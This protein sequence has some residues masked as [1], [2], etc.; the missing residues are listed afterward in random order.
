MYRDRIVKVFYVCCDQNIGW[1]DLEIIHIDCDI[2]S[3]A[4]IVTMT[5]I[6]T[7]F[8]HMLV[9]HPLCLDIYFKIF[10]LKSFVLF[11]NQVQFASAGLTSNRLLMK[12][13]LVKL[14]F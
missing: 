13:I 1:I 8:S 3:E 11:V 14:I 12:K 5:A 4:A 6:E 9:S 10:S 2:R 7:L